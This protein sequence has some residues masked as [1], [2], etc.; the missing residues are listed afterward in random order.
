[1]TP[2]HRRLFLGVAVPAVVLAVVAL[3]GVAYVA[4][5][6]GGER[7]GSP[8]DPGDPR[9]VAWG[10]ALYGEHCAT[11]HGD[12]LQGET[13]DWRSRKDSGALP[14]PPHDGTGHTWHHPDQQLFAI[15]K[16]GIAPFAPAGYVTD[17][18]AF[19]EVLSDAEIWAILAYIKSTWPP[20]ALRA[21]QARTDQAARAG[22]GR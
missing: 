8:A 4:W 10:K 7:M 20:E 3:L 6:V 5:P 9:Q 1:M 22:G 14:A 16:Q 2:R 12:N 11:C 15:T 19:G 21:Q 13:P 18:P 17:M